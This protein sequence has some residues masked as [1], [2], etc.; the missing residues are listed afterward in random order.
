MQPY[1]TASGRQNLNRL[2]GEP[3]WLQPPEYPACPDCGQL[4]RALAQLDWDG[5]DDA[6]GMTYLSWCD[7]CAV[8]ALRH[9]RPSRVPAR[10]PRPG[11]TT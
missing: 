10:A 4:M 2:G 5:L 9:Q 7:G 6:E 1:G 8:S 3:S 11:V